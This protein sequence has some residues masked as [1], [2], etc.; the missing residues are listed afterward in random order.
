MQGLTIIVASSDQERFRS[1]LEVAAA[2]A[3][4]DRPTRLFLQGAAA[5]LLAPSVLAPPRLPD[6]MG[7][8]PTVGELLEETLAL[9]ATMTVCQSGMALAGIGADQL[10]PGVETGGLV[11]ILAT[12]RDH[13]MLMA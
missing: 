1:A 5:A 3:A 11:E 8:A 2:N 9:G 7:G 13:Q 6:E 12:A 4:L 10:P